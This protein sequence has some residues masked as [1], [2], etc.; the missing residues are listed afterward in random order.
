MR[1]IRSTVSLLLSVVLAAGSMSV[2]AAGTAGAAT[3][4]TTSGAS[5]TVWLC[6]PGVV[7]DPCAGNLSYSVVPATGPTG[8]VHPKVPAS[9]PIDC[10]YV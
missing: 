1:I 6:K 4:T 8:V 2:I 3:T 5:S 7:P 10:F 9:P